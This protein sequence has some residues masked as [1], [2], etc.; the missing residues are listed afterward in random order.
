[1]IVALVQSAHWSHV[2]AL[3]V[4]AHACLNVRNV[5]WVGSILGT[6][7]LSAFQALSRRLSQTPSIRL[8]PTGERFFSRSALKPIGR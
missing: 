6:T 3:T 4:L 5:L 8:R 7:A 1:M 2:A